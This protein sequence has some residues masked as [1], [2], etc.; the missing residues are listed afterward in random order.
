VNTLTTSNAS[1]T[2]TLERKSLQ[3][4]G[5]KSDNEELVR[6]NSELKRSNADLKRQIDKWQSLET[7]EGDEVDKLRKRRLELEV[8]VKELESRLD[9]LEKQA[10]ADKQLVELTKAKYEKTKSR[11]QEYAVS[12]TFVVVFFFFAS[13]RV[14]IKCHGGS[15]MPC[16]SATERYRSTKIR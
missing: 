8:Q 7:K 10:E 2:S 5:A 9:D 3:F 4:D 12:T 15:R 13:L 11:L 1:L 14:N 16:Q 6:L